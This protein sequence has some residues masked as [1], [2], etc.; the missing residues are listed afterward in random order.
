[1]ASGK[2]KPKR[3]IFFAVLVPMLL[4]IL[5]EA[6]LLLAILSTSGIAERLNQNDN[7]TFDEQVETRAEYLQT[8]MLTMGESARTLAQEV[9]AHADELAEDGA[10]DLGSIEDDAQGRAALLTASLESMVSSLRLSEASGAFLV[11]NN[12]DLSA[13]HETGAYGRKPGVYLYDPNPTEAASPRNDDLTIEV[14][15]VEVVQAQ[16]ISTGTNWSAF[17]DFG[18]RVY[19]NE[20][21]FLYLPF[22]TAFDEKSPRDAIAYECWSVAPLA[23]SGTQDLSLAYSIPLIAEDGTVFGVV[24]L[25]ISL[26]RLTE[27][28]PFNEILSED[29]GSYMLAQFEDDQLSL[30]TNEIAV[31]TPVL[32]VGFS[33]IENTEYGGHFSMVRGSSSAQAYHTVNGQYCISCVPLEL[34]RSNTVLENNRWALLGIAPQAALHRF[35]EQA[36]AMIGVA[37]LFMLLLGFVGS[38]LVGNR[39]S[40]PLRN[41]SKEVAETELDSSEAIQLSSTG[42]AEVDQLTSAISTLSAN[43]ASA[44][45]LEQERL[46]YERDFDLLTGLMNRRA[47]YRRGNEIFANPDDLKNAAIVMLDLDNLKKFNDAYGHDCGD[48]YIREAA[49]CFEASVPANVLVSRVSG[50]EFF[51]LFYGYDSRDELN[52]DVESLRK[53]VPNTPFELPDGTTT[54]IEASGGVALYLEDSTEFAELMKLADFT[55]YQVKESGKNNIAYFDFDTYQRK[56][57]ALR[58]ES[59]FNDLMEDF[60]LSTYHFQPIFNART[61]KVFAYEAL[62]RVNMGLLKNPLDVLDQARSLDR[63][64]E[65]ERMT[66]NRSLECFEALLAENKVDPNAYLFV[67]SFANLSLSEDE[68]ADIASTHA[69]IMDRVVIEI[70]EVVDMDEKATEIKRQLPGAT[71]WMALDDYGSGYNSEVKLLTLR[72][73]FVKVDTSI[74]RNIHLSEDKQRIVSHVVE[75]AHERNMNII[76]EGVE[77]AEELAQLLELNVDLLQG[78]FLA[79][80]AEEPAELSPEAAE[81]MGVAHD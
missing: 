43:V 26:D 5:A 20:H 74:I 34:Y 69:D 46:E 70:T 17:F 52:A 30:A 22:M 49:Q 57:S 41:L 56:S 66:W 10:L 23:V 32:C 6:I 24:G 51:M 78:Y 80:P 75:Y 7:D 19:A 16:T 15:P 28:L 11:L 63:M 47:F 37:T 71:G 65:V 59:E 35:S 53:T 38:I 27:Y 61:G 14:A 48:R 45:K 62:M 77:N 39:I 33:P 18:E 1:M 76:A 4:L 54:H 13:E 64:I 21:D 44:R 25:D 50:D 29:E 40:A 55:M 81:S 67:N 68:L 60:E 9:S 72:P 12:N 8:M 58:L 36:V 3:S 2:T 73:D 42:I 31:A 79:R